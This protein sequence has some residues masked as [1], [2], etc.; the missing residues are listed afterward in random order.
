M[1]RLETFKLRITTGDQGL[2]G[3]LGYTINGFPLD[4]DSMEG[5][6][7]PG[8]VAELVA[9]PESF[10]H[11]LRLNGPE[12]GE[13]DIA[14][15]EIE[16]HCADGEPYTLRLGGVTLDAQSELN[17]WYERPPVWLDV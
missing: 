2:D 1:P 8:E 15:A 3:R 7:G 16:Y 17:L 6:T 4:F 13:W 9:N 5:G 14:G 11:S 12:S 10:P